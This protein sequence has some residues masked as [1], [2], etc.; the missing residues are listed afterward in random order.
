MGAMEFWP[1]G[2]RLARGGDPRAT[3]D[4]LHLKGN[5]FLSKN[6]ADEQHLYFG[7]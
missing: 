7:S 1:G 5:P 4:K 6:C 3:E 2:D